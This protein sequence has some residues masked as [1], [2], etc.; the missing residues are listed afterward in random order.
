MPRDFNHFR[1]TN[2]PN[3]ILPAPASPKENKSHIKSLVQDP[4]SRRSIPYMRE[5]YA[6]D[7]LAELDAL[8]RSSFMDS[9]P[10]PVERKE[11][12]SLR[13]SPPPLTAPWLG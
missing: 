4:G 12:G 1:M 11:K 6:G 9:E 3:S 8:R 13:P 10:K 2:S 7:L 5:A